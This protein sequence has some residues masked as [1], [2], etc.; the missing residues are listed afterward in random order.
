M[1]N[2]PIL[3]LLVL[4]SVLQCFASD[5]ADPAPVIQ[6]TKVV[7]CDDGNRVSFRK[8]ISGKYG[9]FIDYCSTKYSKCKCY[10]HKRY[11]RIC[12]EEGSMCIIGALIKSP[13]LAYQLGETGL[14]DAIDRNT[15]R[16]IS[17]ITVKPV[18]SSEAFELTEYTMIKPESFFEGLK[19]FLGNMLRSFGSTYKQTV[20]RQVLFTMP[21]DDQSLIAVKPTIGTSWKGAGSPPES[22]MKVEG[23]DMTEFL[24]DLGRYRIRRNKT[25]VVVEGIGEMPSLLRIELK[26]SSGSV[27]IYDALGYSGYAT[28]GK[29]F[30]IK[31]FIKRTKAPAKKCPVRYRDNKHCP[32]T[33]C[34][35]KSSTEKGCP[36]KKV[37]YEDSEVDSNRKDSPVRDFAEEDS[38]VDSNRKDCPMK[39]EET[40]ETLLKNCPMTKYNGKDCPIKNTSIRAKL[41]KL[42]PPLRKSYSSQYSFNAYVTAYGAKDASDFDRMALSLFLFTENFAMNNAYESST[43]FA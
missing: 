10:I 41:V 35:V 31:L 15:S 25:E 9:Q 5:D 11:A 28:M 32:L 19:N 24:Y 34:P 16:L 26:K 22:V 39:D 17:H 3:A 1:R 8:E 18:N 2:L 20:D 6:A 14:A 43:T 7:K 42:C 30:S 12:D 23:G 37:S 21:E 36:L 29:L 13:V 4:I 38:E 33:G 27:R 40:R